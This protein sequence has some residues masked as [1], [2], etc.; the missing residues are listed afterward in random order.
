MFNLFRCLYLKRVSC[1]QHIVRS[2]FFMKSDNLCFLI[3]VLRP[4][5]FNVIIDMDGYKSTILF[6][7]FY[8]SCVFFV[9]FSFSP[10]FLLDLLSIW[11]L[12]FENCFLGLS[13]IT[14]CHVFSGYFRV[15]SILFNLLSLTSNYIIPLH[16]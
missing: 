5:T 2:C 6:S 7:V 4:F 12:L 9:H 14:L 8:L 3:K 13:S 10:V 11:E 1:R 15:C 16:M